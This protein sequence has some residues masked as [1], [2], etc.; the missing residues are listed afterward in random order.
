MNS[1][2][3]VVLMNKIIDKKMGSKPFKLGTIDPTYTNGNPRIIFDGETKPSTKQYTKLNSYQPKPKE[4][5]LL[6][7][8]GR[9]Y[10]VVGALGDSS[11]GTNVDIPYTTVGNAMKLLDSVYLPNDANFFAYMS[12][13]TYANLVTMEQN[14]I[15]K[16]GD[17]NIPKAWFIAEEYISFKVPK[18]EVVQ[19]LNAD[20]TNKTPSREV[21][22]QGNA[23]HHCMLGTDGTDTQVATQN[24]VNLMTILDNVFSVFPA[25]NLTGINYTV[26]RAGVYNFDITAK[27]GAAVTKDGYIRFGLRVNRGGT[28]TD[29]DLKDRPY[30]INTVYGTPFID[31]QFIYK[32]A[33]NDIVTP[34]VKPLTENI[35]LG[36]GSKSNIYYLGDAPLI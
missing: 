33:K 12:D 18:I 22:H 6:A 1:S 23:T 35:T 7:S 29:Y 11:G 14:D 36:A 20:H 27:I 4:R 32:L 16:V 26:P 10:V 25:D 30:H 13:G 3:F 24:A 21:Y 9:T 5:V 34:Y 31:A 2:E 15:F 28:I 19:E 17:Y 8:M